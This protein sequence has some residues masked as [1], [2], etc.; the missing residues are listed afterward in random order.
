MVPVTGVLTLLRA[1]LHRLGT[2]LVILVVALCATAAATVGPTYY[3]A[4]KQSILQDTLTRANDVERGVQA[5]QQ[6]AVQGTLPGLDS[7]LR[8][9]I[10]KALGGPARTGRLFQPPVEAR[11]TRAFLPGRVQNIPFVWRSGV[12][13]QL[14]LQ[15]GR[16]PARAGEV[17]VSTSLATLNDWKVGAAIRPAAYPPLTITGIYRVPDSST[18]YWFGRGDLYFPAEVPTATTAP[19][20]AMF[21]VPASI[22]A[23]RG[24]PQGTVLVARALANARVTPSD[25]D[26]LSRL[27]LVLNTT[28]RLQ[29]VAIAAGLGA[30]TDAVHSSWSALAVPVVLVT[31]ELLVLTWLLLFLVVTDAIE[32]RGTE[33]ALAKLRGYG[34]ARA[35]A[36]GLGEPAL[37]LLVALPVG[38]VL[39]RLI[40]GGL[41]GALLRVGTDV[42]LPGLGWLAASIAVLGGLAAIAVAARSTLTR[43]VV[44][45]WRRTGRRATDR[46]WVFDAV[47]LTGAVAGL[48]Q[49]AVSG[50]LSSAS[51]D[52]LALL[53]PGLLGLA[54]AVVGSRLLPL[55]C[56]ALYARTRRAGGL[57]PFLAVRH[58]ARRPGGTRTTMILA[59]AIALATFSIAAWSVGTTNRNRVADLTV[60]APSVLTVGPSVS[61]ELGGVVERADPGGHHAAAVEVFGSDRTTV[62]AVQPQRFAA[63]ANWNAGF[64]SGP[65]RLLADLSPPAPPPLVVDGDQ[66]RVRLDVGALSVPGLALDLDVV[67]TGATAP[68][69]VSLGTVSAHR[70]VTRIGDLSAC[71]C[72]VRDLSIQPVGPPT[73]V[74]GDVT[75]RGIDVRG[76]NGWRAVDG[77]TDSTRWTDTVDQQVELSSGSGGLHW[78]FFAVRGVP[79]A[80]TVH[81]RPQQLPAVTSAAVQPGNSTFNATGLDAADLPVRVVGRAPAV[82]GAATS[83]VVVDLTYAER[84]AYGDIAAADAQVW[85]RGSTA[86]VRSALADA[87]IPVLSTQT[88]A[89]LRDELTR[90]GPGLAS[91]LFVADAVAAALLAALAAVLSL[92]AA[93]RRRRYEYAALAATGA[94]QRTLYAALAIEQLVV[95]G[96][97]AVTGVGAGLLATALAGRSVPQFVTEPAAELLTYTPSVLLLVLTLTVGVVLLLAAAAMTA[98]ALLRSVSPDQLREAPS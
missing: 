32:A 88:S 62:L 33:I 1:L 86:S 17:M 74:S 9:E 61:G 90:Q 39:G 83:A 66:V 73:Q 48:I 87:G 85:V 89:G 8:S 65:A 4:A 24:N 19:F 31:G 25:V 23:L 2:T 96:F 22:D 50:T 81:D 38:A 91:V 11:E 98:A 29:G 7:R 30:T 20:D 52:P 60:G 44:E 93:A 49:L 63:V 56:R 27:N 36:F 79:P 68:T 72:V 5:S 92:Y 95:I 16:C 3:A 59:T 34:G 53:V 54:L 84:A 47:V 21:T 71:P 10:D 78:T 18:D 69:P 76:T 43:P 64:V 94:T 58:M 6:G 35:L 14:R 75:L 97:G 55:G 80:L 12:C 37:L 77:A 51:T 15:S 67:A 70:S 13:D 26:A 46:S 57:G 41:A 42:T 40:A 28:P 82:P 45:Q